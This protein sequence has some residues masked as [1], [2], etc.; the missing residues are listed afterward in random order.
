MTEIV[1]FEESVRAAFDGLFVRYFIDDLPEEVIRAKICPFLFES[2]KRGV[3]EIF[4]ARGEDRHIGFG[5]CQ[6]DRPESDWCKRPGWGFIREFYVDPAFRRRGVGRALCARIED[7]L[8]EMGAA[9]AYLTSGGAV[10]FWLALGYA[11]SGERTPEG[12]LYLEKS[13]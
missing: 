3:M 8:R 12:L 2:W 5:I 1:R 6:I 9:R 4:L 11:D 10:P 7:R 13:L